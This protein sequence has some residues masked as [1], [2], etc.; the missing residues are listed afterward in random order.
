MAFIIGYE[1]AGLLEAQFTRQGS[2]HMNLL[3][4]SQGSSL[5][6]NEKPLFS[7]NPLNILVTQGVFCYMVTL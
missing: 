5:V 6:G 1:Q 7:Q 3:S 2:D 4:P